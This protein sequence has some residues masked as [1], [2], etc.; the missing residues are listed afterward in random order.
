MERGTKGKGYL[1][2]GRYPGIE[3]ASTGCPR[4][5][6]GQ[7]LRSLAGPMPLRACQGGG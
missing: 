4:S 6:A 7:S 1:V 2:L 3:R 5:K